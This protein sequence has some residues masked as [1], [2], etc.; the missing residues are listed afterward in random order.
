MAQLEDADST[1]TFRGRNRPHLRSGIE[2][3]IPKLPEEKVGEAELDP[4]YCPGEPQRVRVPLRT[5]GPREDL[6]CPEA[7][8]APELSGGS[9]SSLLGAALSLSVK[10][11]PNHFENRFLKIFLLKKPKAPPPYWLFF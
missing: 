8:L 10:K 7:V 1:Y 3:K 11:A 2:I 5:W 9:A 6:G 4:S